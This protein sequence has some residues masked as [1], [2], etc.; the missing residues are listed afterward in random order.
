MGG[1]ERRV[2]R[3]GAHGE[4]VEVRFADGDGAGLSETRDDG[5]VVGWL[6][7]GKDL[8]RARRG[9]TSRTEI[10]LE[11]ERNTCEGPRIDPGGDCLVDAA[12]PLASRIGGEQVEA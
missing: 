4:F 10:V 7:V 11:G 1:S 2:L 8:R 5:G 9:D 3:G 6:P 12:R